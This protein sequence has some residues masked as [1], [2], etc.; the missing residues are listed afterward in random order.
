[1]PQE[2][3]RQPRDRGQPQA[4]RLQAEGEGKPHLRQRARTPLKK[5]HRAGSRVRADEEQHA[6]QTLPPLRQ[7]Q[8][9]DGL[10]LL[11]Y[12]LQH[13]EDGRKNGEIRPRWRKRAPFL[14]FCRYSPF[15]TP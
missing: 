10:C 1:M 14:S 7:R 5:T 8:G 13:Q 2:E 11:R 15:L 6:L 12:C 3:E 4:H 9:H